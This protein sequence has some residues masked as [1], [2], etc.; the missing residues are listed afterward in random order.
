MLSSLPISPILL[1]L[2]F[3]SASAGLLPQKRA[4]ICGS[5][6]Y[7]RGQGNYYY[8]SSAKLATYAACSQ[9]CTLDSKCKSF[10]YST[11]ECMLFSNALSGNFDADSGS[12]DIY[13]D[14]GCVKSVS[15]S[16]SAISSVSS[17]TK[18]TVL[19]TTSKTTVGS[20]TKTTTPGASPT[21]TSASKAS[22]S[23]L[24]T[25]A[26]SNQATNSALGTTTS[27]SVPSA[28]V[29]VPAGCS[30]PSPVTMTSFSWFNSTHNLVCEDELHLHDYSAHIKEQYTRKSLLELLG[31]AADQRFHR[32]AP[33]LTTHQPLRCAGIPRRSARL[34][35]QA[36]HAHPIATRAFL[37][38]PTS[39]LA[40]ALPTP[41]ML[42]LT[43]PH[44]L[45]PI[46]SLSVA[47]RSERAILIAVVDRIPSAF[48]ATRTRTQETQ[49][50][51]ITM[52]TTH[53]LAMDWLRGTQHR[54]R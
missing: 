54:S 38:M 28:S 19:S 15:T 53:Q 7:D 18:T 25:T 10:G 2:L 40:S 21:S 43:V 47:G 29:T 4:D 8:S 3:S 51:F 52:P 17:T 41:S 36:A 6:G 49:A 33:I 16:S 27:S 34:A 46:H 12:S 31:L 35:M 37:P 44:T 14:R 11:K 24:K 22:S 26:A 23:S 42:R 48:M 1:G 9:Q 45:V 39:L 5:K 32:I 50:P 13:Y 20:T 30:V